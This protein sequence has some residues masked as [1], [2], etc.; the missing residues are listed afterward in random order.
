MQCLLFKQ[1]EEEWDRSS[2]LSFIA[3]FRICSRSLRMYFDASLTKLTRAFQHLKIEKSADPPDF[4]IFLWDATTGK[5]RLPPIDW[6]YFM[7]TADFKTKEGPVYFHWLDSIEALSL[8]HMQKNKAF[9][10]VRD[11]KN[12]PWW[13]EGCPLQTIVH[14][15][16]QERGLQLTHT[17]A[18]GDET[19][20]LL[21]T[22]K[23]GSGKSTT[24]LSCLKGGL[25][26]IGEDHAVLDL[27]PVSINGA[28]KVWSIYQSAKWKPFTRTLF[29]DYETHIVNPTSADF[30][31]ALVFYDALFPSQ[32]RD[33]LPIR[34]IVSLSVGQ[35]RAP[36]LNSVDASF[37]VQQLMLSTLQQLPFCG[38]HTVAFFK[39]IGASTKHYHLVLGRNLEEN[40]EQLKVLLT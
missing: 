11:A 7:Q 29:P 2:S 15:W 13:V 37:A 38:P 17:A 24:A 5:K 3:D 10:L 40:V 28:P 32:I 35:E 34:A 30:E 31:K 14:A 26:Y 6:A 36:K 27:A 4:T 20:A 21:L 22:G 33:S 18:I 16:L 39:K 8:I 9:Y 1:L 25:N 12:L 23:G 19:G